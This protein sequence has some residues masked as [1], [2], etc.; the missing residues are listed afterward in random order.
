VKALD[1][2]D[3]LSIYIFDHALSSPISI[4]DS[5]EVLPAFAL[6]ETKDPLSKNP[7]TILPITYHVKRFFN[8]F[9]FPLEKKIGPFELFPNGPKYLQNVVPF[10][11]GI[12]LSAQGNRMK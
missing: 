3:G 5:L 7:Q 2:F 1:F 10:V 8:S 12:L 6:A 11:K 4:D 9:F